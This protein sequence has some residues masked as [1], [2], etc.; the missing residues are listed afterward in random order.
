MANRREYFILLQLFSRS[1]LLIKHPN[2]D[3]S[4]LIDDCERFVLRS[5]DA[6]KQSA[7]HIYH[8]A[9]P[10]TPT[11][12]PTRQL[13][14]CKLMTK[15]KLVNAVSPTWDACIRIIPVAVG[16][17]IEAVVFSPSGALIAAHEECCVQVFDAMTGVNRAAFYEHDA[18][19][20]AA[21]SPDDGFLMS[22]VRGGTINIWDVQTG[23]LFRTFK[24]DKVYSAYSVV[25]SSCGTM[26]ASGDDDETVRIWN[27]LSGGCVCV[28]AGHS[29]TVTDV[30][31]LGTW[32]QVV[33]ASDD[34]T[35]RI[36][37]V[38]NSV[39]TVDDRCFLKFWNSVRNKI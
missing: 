4:L 1:S 32:N 24:L 20:S 5:F 36:W 13:Y 18:I 8:S 15:T 9:L 16:E 7:M 22:G 14:E 10:W 29:A 37:D 21:F 25:F 23:T 2:R 38:Q 28:L 31:C 3:L 35:V 26:I 12:S 30:C 19:C 33:S 11:S 17:R 6:V 27:I 34:H 39:A